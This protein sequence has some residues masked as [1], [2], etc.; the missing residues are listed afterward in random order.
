[1]QYVRSLV[2]AR[3]GVGIPRSD[4]ERAA[5]F[6]DDAACLDYLDW[7]RW[8]AG[9]RCPHC[10]AGRS[11]RL[12]DG[13]RSCAG[14]RRRISPTA[15]TVLHR[16]RSPLPLWFAASWA[17][18]EGATTSA[19]SLQRDLGLGSYQ[20]AWAMLH[21]LRGAMAAGG[22]PSL[23]GRV[24]IGAVPL[25]GAR[26]APGTQPGP[27]VLLAVAVERRGPTLGRC[28]L[29]VV[30]DADAGLRSFVRSSVPG[31]AGRGARPGRPASASVHQVGLLVSSWLLG[32][33]HGG[34]EE[35]HLPSYL[36]EFSFRFDGRGPPSPGVRFHR[37][38]TTVVTSSPM[39]AA[40][41]VR[42]PA[43]RTP[44]PLP[45]DRPRRSPPRSGTGRPERPWRTR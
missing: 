15:G 8:E 38:L 16:A 32:P 22:Q 9:F 41:L 6:G 7:L 31:G 33:L 1:M 25:R 42:H 12:P 44:P 2:A 34:V 26:R 19:S 39:G 23:E 36:D 4:A 27:E 20:T 40:S 29:A 11:W 45:P 28:R 37:L 14:C 10:G 35:A 21:R 43:P 13:R 5:W 17:I 18:A 30:A 24:D 3:A